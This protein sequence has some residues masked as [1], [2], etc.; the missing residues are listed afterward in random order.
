[1]EYSEIFSFTTSFGM[2]ATHSGVNR[3][4]RVL[5]PLEGLVRKI[6]Q[7]AKWFRLRF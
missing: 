3:K 6:F 2:N 7:R 1:M 4:I 5:E